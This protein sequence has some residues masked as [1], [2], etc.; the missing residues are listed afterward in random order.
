[1]E[2]NAKRVRS[3]NFSNEEKLHCLH[4]IKKYKE[5]IESKKNWGDQLV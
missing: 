3:A 4:L 2:P 1:M 5:V